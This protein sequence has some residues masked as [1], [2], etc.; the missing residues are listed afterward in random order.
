MKKLSGIL[1]LLVILAA[2][3]TFAHDGFKLG[4]YMVAG[5]VANLTDSTL[6]YSQYTTSQSYP[7]NG[8]YYGVGEIFSRIRIN[9]AY[10]RENS[11]IDFRYQVQKDFFDSA[12]LTA[13]NLKFAQMY[14]RLLDGLFIAEAG[15]LAD[16]YTKANGVERFCFS[17][18]ASQN[19]K[20]VRLVAFPI[21]GL[22][23][24][25]QVSDLHDDTN[26]EKK[27]KLNKNLLSFSAKYK[28]A[29]FAVSAGYH[30]AKDA[31]IGFDLYA[32][33]NLILG[34]EARYSGEKAASDL[35]P[36]K[37]ASLTAVENIEY[38]P[39]LIQ[40]FSY[41]FYAKQY[42]FDDDKKIPLTAASTRFE[43]TPHAQYMF[44]S[45]Y[46]VQIESTV[47]KYASCKSGESDIAFSATYALLAAVT[48][49]GRGARLFYTVLRD[50][51]K[52]VQNYIGCTIRVNL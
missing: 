21:E 30:L 15:V 26:D 34:I 19:V 16:K 22:A 50:C 27:V 18:Y 1:L 48:T 49:G 25:A 12:N 52:K 2:G 29:G 14:A 39:A 37:T 4:G 3:R 10:E 44:N 36:F 45:L 28:N 35:S 17:D 43:F 46:G 13:K 8:G 20:G 38:R 11:G 23:F 24:S 6:D 42:V 51:N 47:T 9:A 41:G 31:Y 32:I 33:K 7:V 40:G 5:T